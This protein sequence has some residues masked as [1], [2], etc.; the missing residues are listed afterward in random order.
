MIEVRRE[1]FREMHRYAEVRTA[2]LVMS[3]L[4]PV[5]DASVAAGFALEEHAVSTPYVKDYDAI[6]ENHPADWSEYFDTTHWQLF[7]AFHEGIRVGGAI[8]FVAAAA[9]GEQASLATLWDLRVSPEHRRNGV[10]TALFRG[11]EIWAA[12]SGCEALH[13]ETQNINV[14]ACRFYARQ[15]CTL[16]A[17]RPGAYT[18][19]PDEVRLIY[20]AILRRDVAL[21][22]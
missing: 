4:Q 12:A 7:S 13:I 17:V 22:K 15:G 19:F 20:R 6:A 16:H 21:K 18:D 5:P 8:A 14:A 11:V 10:A 2:F 9:D 3:V 1:T